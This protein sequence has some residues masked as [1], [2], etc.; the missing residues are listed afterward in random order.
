MKFA[1]NTYKL[2]R[3]PSSFTVVQNTVVRKTL[4][5]VVYGINGPSG[6]PDPIHVYDVESCS[7]KSSGVAM[8][9]PEA[10]QWPSVTPK[11]TL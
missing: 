10:T 3:I 5:F 11:K 1:L 6:L 4:Y 9:P 7:S 8:A 2:R